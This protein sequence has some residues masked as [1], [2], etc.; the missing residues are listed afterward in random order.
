MNARLLGAR[1]W[2]STRPPTSEPSLEPATDGPAPQPTALSPEAT[3]FNDTRMPGVGGAAGAG[4]ML[5]SFGV[6]TVI[7]LAVAMVLYIR[8]KKRLEKLR[9]QLMPMYSFDP[10]EEQ[11]E[12][13][14][15]L[16]EHAASAQAPPSK[17]TLPAQGPVQRP[18]RLVFTDVA[19]AIHA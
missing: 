6:I 10:T 11:D 17:T 16:L 3:S 1:D 19:I 7:G 4:T 8:K 14:Q 9:H 2:L 18:S 5:L 15:E 13:E 12:L